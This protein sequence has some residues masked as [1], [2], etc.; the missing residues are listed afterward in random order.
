MRRLPVVLIAAVAAVLTVAGFASARMQS[1]KLSPTLCET[2]GGGKFVD[3][4]DFPGERIDRRLLRDVRYLERRYKI[5][6]TDGYSMDDVHAAN[7]EHPIGLALDIVPNKAAG[8]TWNDIDRLAEWAEP[9]QNEPRPPFRWVGYDGD[10]GHGRGHH[11][12][13][14]FGHSETRPGV[15]AKLVQSIRCPG[16]RGGSPQPPTDPPDPPAPDP[17][18]PTDPDS[19][20]ATARGHHRDRDRDRDRTRD[21][22][23]DRDRDNTGGVGDPGSGGVSAKLGLAPPVIET[24]GVGR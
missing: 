8:G 1:T 20:G 12:H 22:D 4:P 14:S 5:F 19:G 10:S 17:V 3:I 7:G 18:E 13:L 6:V 24:G 16:P 9:V 11:L 23:R 2:T 21:R 15:P